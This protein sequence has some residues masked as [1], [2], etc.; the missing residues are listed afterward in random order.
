MKGTILVVDDEPTIAEAVSG[1]LEDE[2][3]SCRVAANGREALEHARAERPD[4]VVS[5]VMMP[6]LD[7]RRLLAEIRGD[8]SLKELPVV[9]MSAARSV[10][11]GLGA[12]HDGFLAKPFTIDELLATVE[13]VLSRR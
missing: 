12:A 11:D 1:V 9:L 13:R 6:I 3:Y 5:D 8:P 2:G 10:G 7:G 4:L